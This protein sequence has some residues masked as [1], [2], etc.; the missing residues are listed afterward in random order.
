MR[1]EESKHNSKRLSSFLGNPKEEQ[2]GISSLTH[3]SDLITDN[4]CTMKSNIL[5]NKFRADHP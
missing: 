2:R 3:D 1:D 5:I 4:T